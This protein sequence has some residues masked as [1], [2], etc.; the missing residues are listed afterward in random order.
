MDTVT[1]RVVLN[2][3]HQF[4]GEV[5]LSG[6]KVASVHVLYAAIFS[7]VS[8]TFHNFHF[9]E[10]VNKIIATLE[11]KNWV[12]FEFFDNGLIFHP[13]GMNSDIT[14][15]SY[16]RA[17]ICIAS[18][19]G[20]LMGKIELA[21]VGGCNF[22]NRPIDGHIRILHKLGFD[23][24]LNTG[25]YNKI[26]NSS[27]DKNQLITIDC[28]TKKYGPSVG[29]TCH[30]LIA[31]MVSDNN[32]K[33]INIA[34]EPACTTIIE[35]ISK[36]TNKI[37]QL[38]SV[39]RV[40]EIS[41]NSKADSN[42]KIIDINIPTDL[43]EMLTYISGAILHRNIIHL[44]NITLTSVVKRLLH[45]LNVNIQL[46]TK[47]SA[48]FD[49]R[50]IKCNLSDLYL[51]VWPAIPSDAGPVIAVAFLSLNGEQKIIDNVYDKRSAHV[52]ELQKLGFDIRSRGNI[53][54]IGDKHKRIDNVCVNANDIRSG[55]AV[56]L[57]ATS[58]DN[59]I[60]IDNFNQVERGYRDILKNFNS[61]GVNISYE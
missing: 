4:G 59:R 19:I 32:F 9:C 39:D 5:T 45:D 57:A 43:T 50:N 31:S 53:I 26:K 35:I 49:C 30:A 55:A 46:I 3:P 20:I 42:K 12:R 36:V 34:L 56:L 25:T 23:G 22:T 44:N 27:T 29:M 24:N 48:L 8:I 33:L 7:P 61:L 52:P 14:P 41:K 47:T 60:E 1:S 17:S 11:N 18:A 15:F 10:D 51:D 37:V 28:S 38:D 13:I 40:V 16:S 6:D 54:I 2:G 58:L 21:K